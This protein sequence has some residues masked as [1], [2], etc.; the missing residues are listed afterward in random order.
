MVNLFTTKHCSAVQTHATISK[1]VLKT[2]VSYKKEE[3]CTYV[4]QNVDGKK[5]GQK[6][7]LAKT[8]IFCPCPVRVQDEKMIY[9]F[10]S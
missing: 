4:A 1:I 9:N 7:V 10:M 8:N 2:V 3:S 5:C 6:S